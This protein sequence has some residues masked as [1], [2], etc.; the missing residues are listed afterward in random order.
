[1]EE[2]YKDLILL[3]S[4]LEGGV[5]AAREDVERNYKEK[6]TSAFSKEGLAEFFGAMTYAQIRPLKL[7][8]DK[9]HVPPISVLRVVAKTEAHQN[10]M[11]KES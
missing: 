9:M 6:N 5:K 7:M 10:L 8:A 3:L 4:T 1:M 2:K 11:R